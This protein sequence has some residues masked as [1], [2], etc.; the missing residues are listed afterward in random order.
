VSDSS[1]MAL[2][3]WVNHTPKAPSPEKEAKQQAAGE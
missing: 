1:E 2:L 3:E